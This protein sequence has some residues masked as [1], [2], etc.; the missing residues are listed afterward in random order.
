VP[1][2]KRE[3]GEA[4]V[5]VQYVP[6]GVNHTLWK[7]ITDEEGLKAVAAMRVRIFGKDADNVKFVVMYNSRNIRRKM[8]SDIILA[9]REFLKTIPETDR[10]FCRLLLHTQPVDENGTDLLA[11]LR[12]LAPDVQA[13]FSPDRLSAVEMVQLYN[14]ADVIISMTSNEGFG[15]GTL[16]AM[17]TERMIIANVTGGLQDQMGFVDEHGQLLDPEVHFNAEWDTNAD[18]K[19]RQHGEWVIPLFPTNRALIGSPITP[20]IFDDRCSY[21]DAARAIREVYDMTPEERH[22]RG[23]LGREYALRPDVGMTAELM[24]DRLIK[25]IEDTFARWA[26]KQKFGIYKGE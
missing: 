24:C 22:R 10:P 20:Y 15:I 6:H 17:M 1:E 19:Y 2:P 25:G 21:T 5:L 13:V 14:C 8:T 3:A 4:P 11:V 26:P 7:N 18:G 23:K 16:E 9:Y 12:D